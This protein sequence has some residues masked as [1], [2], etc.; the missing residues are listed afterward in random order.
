M[1]KLIFITLMLGVLS[2]THQIDQNFV[3]VVEEIHEEPVY[4]NF[5]RVDLVQYTISFRKRGTNTHSG[6]WFSFYDKKDKFQLHDTLKFE[7][8]VKNK[9]KN[10]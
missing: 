5:K 7:L 10:H 8:E 2:C 4:V 3:P 1:K 9:S 6:W